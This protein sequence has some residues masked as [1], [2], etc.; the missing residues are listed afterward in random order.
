MKIEIREATP[1][2]VKALLS[3]YAPYVAETAITYEYDIPTEE[4]FAGR[5]RNTLCKYPY[6]VAMLDGKIVGYAYAGTFK[7]RRAY[8]CSVETSIYIDKEHHGKG[9]GKKLYAA[10]EEKL[11]VLGITNMYAC[12]AYTEHEDEYLTNASVRFHEK[13]GFTLCGT[14][15]RC[16]VKFDRSYDMVWMEKFIDPS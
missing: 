1:E 11:K 15:H 10:L 8:D 2:D 12:I 5:I 4:D 13:M 9:I 3:I 14:F 7:G 6:L 16:A